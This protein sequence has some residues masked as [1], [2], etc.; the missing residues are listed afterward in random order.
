MNFGRRRKIW[1]KFSRNIKKG[2]GTISNDKSWGQTRGKV[3][4]HNGGDIH[5]GGVFL[6][7]TKRVIKWLK[8]LLESC[9]NHGGYKGGGCL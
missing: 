3:C 1:E 5:P 7:A 8:G 9:E 4:W 6:G 2:V